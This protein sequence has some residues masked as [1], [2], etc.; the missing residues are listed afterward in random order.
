VVASGRDL[1]AA[2]ADVRQA[3]GLTQDEVATAAGLERTYLAKIEAG[4]S[5]L[6]LDRA[7][8]A[9]RALGARV[10]VTMDDDGPG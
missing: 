4:S 7:L 10:T 6:R 3:R 5:V 9:L 2:L 8:V 1:G